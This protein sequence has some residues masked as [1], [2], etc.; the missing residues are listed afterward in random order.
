MYRYIPVLFFTTV[1]ASACAVGIAKEA[2]VH[3]T[4]EIGE[5]LAPVCI[6]LKNLQHHIYKPVYKEPFIGP[7]S[8][9]ECIIRL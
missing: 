3:E 4:A 8:I 1:G 5:C 6:K 9:E 7:V 2:A